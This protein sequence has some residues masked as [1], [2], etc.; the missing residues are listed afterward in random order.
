M[1]GSQCPFATSVSVPSEVPPSAILYTPSGAT[2]VIDGPGLWL[3]PLLGVPAEWV[4]TNGGAPVNPGDVDI[5]SSDIFLTEP[6]WNGFNLLTL[7]YTPGPIPFVNNVGQTL[8][9]FSLPLP[10][11]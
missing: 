10:F 8:A 1:V 6:G 9:A 11:P 4:V 5:I 2:I 7:T 3:S